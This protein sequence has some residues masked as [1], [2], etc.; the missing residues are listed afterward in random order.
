[1]RER[2]ISEKVKTKMTL[3][4]VMQVKYMR[5]EKQRLGWVRVG[6]EQWD[7]KECGFLNKGSTRP[8]TWTMQLTEEREVKG[9]EVTGNRGE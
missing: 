6:E 9:R 5:T 3:S 7:N 8:S 2:D 4:K 1:M